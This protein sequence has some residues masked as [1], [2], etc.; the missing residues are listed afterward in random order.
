MRI[1]MQRHAP[2]TSPGTLPDKPERI[3]A[4]TVRLVRY[5]ADEIHEAEWSGDAPSL[6]SEGFTT[7]ID[8]EGHDVPVEQIPF[9]RGSVFAI[10]G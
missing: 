4:T 2:G 6:T 9:V 10:S 3:G 7:W 8:A 5:R 1:I